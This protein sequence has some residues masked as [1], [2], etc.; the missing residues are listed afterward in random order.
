VALALEAI[1]RAVPDLGRCTVA[2]VGAAGNIGAAVARLLAERGAELILIGRDRPGSLAGLGRLQIPGA[3][4]STCPGDCRAAQVVVVSVSSPV[5]VVR[6]DHLGD[7]AFVCDLSVPTGVDAAGR[8]DVTVLRGGI[9]RLPGGEH[10]Q[11]PGLPLEKGQAFACMAEG[12]VLALEGLADRSFTGDIQA[13]HVH[14]IA[15][16]ASKHGF[17]LAE[18]HRLNRGR[19]NYARA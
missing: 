6:G 12:L 9:A 8:R 10:F 19:V 14:Q 2:V 18:P 3:R 4:L 1:E 13:D 7:G 15:R 5:P 11:I 16:L 17:A